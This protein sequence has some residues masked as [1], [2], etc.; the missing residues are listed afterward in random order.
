MRLR[1]MLLTLMIV[2]LA[3]CGGQADTTP[4]PATDSTTAQTAP[5]VAAN[6]TLLIVTR[7]ALP[8]PMEGALPV[9]APGTLVA[10]ET[11]DPTAGLTFTTI[12]FTR[13]GGGTE[14]QPEPSVQI[15][16]NGDGTFIRNGVSGTL[17]P[18][19]VAAINDMITS[20]NFFG[21]QGAMLG[22]GIE[23]STVYRYAVTIQRGDLNR[24]LSS[25]DGFM[26][27]EY[28]MLLGAIFEVG[29]RP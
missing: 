5:T 24:T 18:D 1:F 25:M 22:A 23:G 9:A 28:I 29:L 16:L 17:S 3:A 10:S 2:V 6:P 13:T 21:L 7:E 4:I 12:E 15:I 8:T 26:P 11:E 14:E 19:R 20:V 27:Q